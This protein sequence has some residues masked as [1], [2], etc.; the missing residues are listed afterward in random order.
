MAKGQ[1]ILSLCSSCGGGRKVRCA[2]KLYF[3]RHGESEA[4]LL[5][6]FSNRGVKHSLTARGRQQATTLAQ[7]LKGISVAKLF[8]SPLLRA[9]QTADILSAKLGAPYEITDALREYDCGILEGNSDAASWEMYDAV[10]N[11]WIQHGHW[12]RRI[13]QGESFLDIKERFVPFVERL[14]EEYEHSPEN[15][16]LVGHG[17]I[18]RCMLP[19]ILANIDF[20]FAIAHSIGNTEYV[21]A[22]MGTEGLTCVTWCESSELKLSPSQY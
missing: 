5:H 12:E 22:E 9:V 19:L 2:M 16:V 6:E 4:N 20:D 15:I 1:E 17:G 8:S 7:K 10:F 11:D 21:V 3:V 13:E 14:V 18:Y